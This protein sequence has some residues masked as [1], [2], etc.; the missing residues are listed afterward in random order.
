MRNFTT[1]GVL[2][3]ALVVLALTISTSYT[4]VTPLP[5]AITINTNLK[6]LNNMFGLIFPITVQQTL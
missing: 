5:G 3:L 1:R 2:G 6:Y 4:Q